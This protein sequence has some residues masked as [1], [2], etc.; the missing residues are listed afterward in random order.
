MPNKVT[1][2]KRPTS[3][4]AKMPTDQPMLL[5]KLG[6]QRPRSWIVTELTTEPAEVIPIEKK[7]SGE[8]LC[9]PFCAASFI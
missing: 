3:N 4:S 6:N 2:F 1:E 9:F 5:V 8:E 7:P